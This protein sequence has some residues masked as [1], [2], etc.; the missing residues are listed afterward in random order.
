MSMCCYVVDCRFYL[1]IIFKNILPVSEI[2]VPLQR[3]NKSNAMQ[4]ALRNNK[5][6]YSGCGNV[7]SVVVGNVDNTTLFIFYTHVLF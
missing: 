6:W 1:K 4:V 5:L 3:L 2:V 7:P